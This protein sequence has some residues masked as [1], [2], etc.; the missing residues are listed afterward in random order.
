MGSS[1]STRMDSSDSRSR[2]EDS[3]DEGTDLATIL[4]ILIRSG[5]VQVAPSDREES[6]DD[7]GGG[8]DT[9]SKPEMQPNTES[10]D[11]SQLSFSTKQSCGLIHSSGH[12]RPNSVTEMVKLRERGIQGT[13]GFSRGDCCKI[14]NCYLPNKKGIVASYR[15]KAFCGTYSKDGNVFLS[16]CQDRNL[17]LHHT[18]DGKFE[19]FKTIQARDVGWSI[20]DTA[21]SPDCNHIA[22][23]SW[24]ECIHLCSI[25]GDSDNQ[26]ALPLHPDERRF[27]IFSLVFSLDNKEILGGANDGHLYVY[28]RGSQQRCLRIKGHSDDVNTVAFADD[29][30]QILF[31]G[32]DDGLCKVWDRRTLSEFNP[33]PVGVHAGHM[34]GV[35]FVDPRGDGRHLITNSKDQSIKLWDMRTFSSS[36]GEDNTRKAVTDQTWDYRWQR[37]PKK[38]SNPKKPLVGDTSVMTYRGHTVL[39]TLVRCHFS[40]E[41]TTGQR[42]IYTGCA[43]GRVIIYDVLTGEIASILHGHDEC[44]RDVSWHP[45]RQELI[46]TS[47]DGTIGQWTHVGKMMDDDDDNMEGDGCDMKSLDIDGW[48]HEPKV[49]RRSK[50]IA[51]KKQDEQQRQ[52]RNC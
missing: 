44:V 7:G 22:Y 45:Y 36:I 23:S 43:E 5:Q 12:A 32:G 17:R 52:Q 29:T 3:F 28:D 27:C 16:A 51:Q 18:C 40:P 30:S 46:S 48:V 41:F 2:S 31:S 8:L 37:V 14:S 42:Y 13:N 24:S 35:T 25:Y 21:F 26:E 47:W 33:R 49:L 9:A 11:R 20:L 1:T 19:L 6:D 10:L 15:S 50:R 34:D 39:Q 4:Q 38:L